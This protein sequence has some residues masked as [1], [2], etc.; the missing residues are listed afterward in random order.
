VRKKVVCPIRLPGLRGL[1]EGR[2][3]PLQFICQSRVVGLVVIKPEMPGSIGGREF[4]SYSVSHTDQKRC[5]Y[6]RGQP[7]INLPVARIFEARNKPFPS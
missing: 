5:H 4:E 1:L 7:P 3:M 2:D 6:E